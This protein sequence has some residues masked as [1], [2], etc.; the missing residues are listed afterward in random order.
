MST[1]VDHPVVDPATEL[2]GGTLVRYLSA[3]GMVVLLYDCLLTID[4]EV[5]D[6]HITPLCIRLTVYFADSACLSRSSLLPQISV[7][8]LSI[9]ISDYNDIL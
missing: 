6:I 3:V 9:P 5:R 2:W 4:Y 1:T 8:H 7:L